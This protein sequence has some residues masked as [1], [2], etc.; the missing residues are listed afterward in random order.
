M[1]KIK[2]IQVRRNRMNRALNASGLARPKILIFVLVLLCVAFL[3][4]L[5]LSQTST[6]GFVSGTLMDQSGAL[7]TGVSVTL[8]QIGTNAVLTANTDSAGR[9][10]FPVVTPGT[11]SLKFSKQGFRTRVVNKL[12]VEVAKSSTVD[13]RLE[14]GT[15]SDIVEVT[16]ESGMTEL[17]TTDAAVGEVLSG[18]ELNRMPVAGRSAARLVFYQ[19]A[20]APDTPVGL[21]PNSGSDVG[22]GQIAGSRS[23]QVTFYLD[24]G[25]AT[26]DLEGSNSY[27]TP[28]Q[29][30]AGISPVVP[31][32]QDAIDEFR[33]STNNP[34]S[35]YGGSSGGQISM[36]SKSGTNAIHGTVY[37]YHDDS[38]L[39]AN[40]WTN[41]HAGIP[42]PF[43]IDNRFGAGAGGPI[44]KDKLFFYGF[45]EGRRFKD[46][47]IITR[48]V[49]TASLKS[50]IITD[51]ASLATYNFNPA[52]GPLASNCGA[53]ACDPRGLGVSPAVMA[54]L[55]L[56]P[57]GNDPSQGDGV[58]TI[59]DLLNI[60]TPISSDIGKLKL[61]YSFN[62]KW[63]AFGTYQYSRT[64]RTGT[65]QI[66]VLT[67]KS[68]SSDPYYA[69]F[70]TFQVTGALTPTFT[71][72]THGSFL[73][74]WW[75][76]VRTTPSPQIPGIVQALQIAGEGR[77]DSSGT[78]KLVADPININTQQARGRVWDGHDW[79][80]AQDFT[81]VKG[82]HTIQFG[83]TGRIWHDFHLRTDDVLGGLTSAPI[84]YVGSHDQ[85][86]M[87]NV[88]ISAANQPA[89]GFNC[90][91]VCSTKR[92]NGLYAALLGLVD[93]SAQI[94]T[95]DG[96][97][98]ANSLGTPL[99]DNVTIPS[100]TT[101]LQDVW[102]ARPSL[103]ITAGLNWGAQISPSEQSGKE[104]VLTY[105]NGNTPVNYREYL[106]NRANLLGQGQLYNP[107]FGLVPVNHLSYPFTKQ[108]RHT[109]WTDFGPRIAVAYQLPDQ[110]TVIR[111][112]YALV[113]DRSSAVNQVLSPL[114]TGGL[115]DVASCAGPVIGGACSGVTTGPANAFRIGVDGNSVPVPAP[116]S[117]PIP[118]VPAAPFGLFLSAPLDPFATPGYAHSFDL[119]VQR[120]LGHQFT[121]ELGYIGKFSRNLP[122]GESLTSPYY[123][124]KDPVSGQTYA[125]A[126]D[127]AANQTRAGIDPILTPP[128]PQAFF[129]NVIGTPTCVGFGFVSCTQ[130]VMFEDGGDLSVSDL[131]SFGTFEVNF[132]TPQFLDNMQVFE[133]A[134]ITDHGYSN[135]N[136][137]FLSLKKAFSQGLQFQFNWTWSHAIGN[138]GTNQQYL[139]SSNSPYNI[140]LD[141]S[142]ETFDHRH[143][144]NTT[145][146]YE[147]P[148][149]KGK[150]FGTDSGILDRIIG[151][152]STA[153]IFSYYT[154]A[155][156]CVNAVGN[157]GSFFTNDCA[158][159]NVPK[160]SKHTLADGSVNG[161][162]DPAAVSSGLQYPQLSV[163]T[164]IP[165]D[166]LRAFPYW[167]IDF[168]LTK[169]L[170]VTERFKIVLGADALNIFNHTVLANPDEFGTL[171]ATLAGT[172]QFGAIDSQANIERKLQLGVRIEF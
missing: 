80:I 158:F 161:F 51:P 10:I 109:D 139:V 4:P 82:R 53:G 25:D 150:R 3:A 39:N 103:T 63:S 37:E 73:R 62:S 9:Y 38:G 147:L 36:L 8:T 137:G 134:G 19:P 151:G 145:W 138:G 20:V 12:V 170:A 98:N 93:H 79:F 171:D 131:N 16:A 156:E 15:Q 142:S 6:S 99:F 1:H 65:E 7:V 154:G 155:P 21:G 52:N 86:N 43:S 143:V 91:P 126:F 119:T 140:N 168:G 14:V 42:K 159:G 26:S 56:L 49:P 55:A 113:Y 127:F 114:L 111:G 22:N 77:G 83:G 87:T 122:Q 68:V 44:I 130:E 92:Y 97:F 24:G 162:A 121:L 61:N 60:P 17:Q 160:M 167:N 116:T 120:S 165:F 69:N 23:E 108:M 81:A 30:S 75:S 90:T 129:E 141:K 70:Y 32:P 40:G 5:G 118:F 102:K 71:S 57:A 74:N 64:K 144:I 29:E 157:Y 107:D 50:G 136:A 27:V 67:G 59:G 46:N 34:N 95:R 31:V 128:T 18:A 166:E 164:K 172:T 33:V 163:N 106:Q 148:F 124:M 110:K 78:G 47:T 41:N 85:S 117:Q 105:A 13:E 89:A 45:Y 96:N 149:G 101:Y 58:N 35:S 48:I 76:W 135:Y 94:E 146:Y 88:T 84:D 112:G 2:F 152:W 11:Y 54:Q 133:F 66:D 153:G 100:F 169:T 123:K 125:Q 132:L 72:V 28:D 115:A 104:V